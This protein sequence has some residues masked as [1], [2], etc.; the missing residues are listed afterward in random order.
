MPGYHFPTD[1]ALLRNMNSQ[2]PQCSFPT[3]APGDYGVVQELAFT[4]WPHAYGDL[5]SAAQIS[6]MID[7]M[8][9]PSRIAEE[10]ESLKIRYHW[11]EHED[12]RSGYLAFGPVVSATPS[13]LHKLYL[14]PEFQGLGLGS[15]ALRWVLEELKIAGASELNLRVNRGNSAAI[16]CYERS[17]FHKTG[18][19]CLDIG[20]GFV[21]DDFLMSHPISN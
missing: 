14:L 8:Y 9:S 15:Q 21:M 10:V 12:H 19:D 5:I 6:Y 18:L 2:P 1:F 4:I 16:R 20:E 3:V 7:Q 13:T 11:I 17:G